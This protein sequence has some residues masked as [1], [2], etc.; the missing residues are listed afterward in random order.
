MSF[1]ITLKLAVVVIVALLLLGGG[2]WVLVSRRIL[3]PE[4]VERLPM[5]AQR[6]NSLRMAA[7]GKS[8]MIGSAEGTVV[9]WDWHAR[10]SRVLEPSSSQPIV[11]LAEANDGLLI[12]TGLQGQLRGWQL[13]EFES[14]K[15]K[16]PEVPVTVMAFRQ[17]DNERTLIFGLADGRIATSL[18]GQLMLRRSGHR[19]LKGLLLTK[20]QDVLVS[21]GTEGKLVWFDLKSSK[22]LTAIHAHRTEI[23]ALLPSPDQTRFV[24]GDW[25]GRLCGWDAALRTLVW[26]AQQSDAVSGLVWLGDRLVSGS[27]DGRLRVWS[28]KSGSPEVEVTIDTGRPILGLV[29]VPGEGL[30]AT[31]SGSRDVEVWNVR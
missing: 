27:W 26:D 9:I 22:P 12:A 14:V 31:V 2:V 13:P 17:R 10:Q 20:E 28:L 25:N 5:P 18:G 11:T 23:S 19:G 16:S 6:L 3:P 1:R 24:T 21:V 29:V 15:L 8:L 30:I 4:F 7:D